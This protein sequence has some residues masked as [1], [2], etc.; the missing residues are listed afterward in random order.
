MI[1]FSDEQKMQSKLVAIAFRK[2]SSILTMNDC[3]YIYREDRRLSDNTRY[4][5]L[6]NTL[7]MVVKPDLPFFT[8]G[9]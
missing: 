2:V 5:Q 8:T 4:Q 9:F 1:L 3:P 7:C 6:S